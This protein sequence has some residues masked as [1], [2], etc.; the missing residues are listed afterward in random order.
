MD[1]IDTIMFYED[2]VYGNRLLIS[3]HADQSELSSNI[4]AARS[5]LFSYND[6]NIINNPHTFSFEHKNPE[7]TI[8]S[9]LGD[10]KGIMSEKGVAAGF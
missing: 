2:E 4:R 1:K 10:R 8:N 5:V 7:Y 3:D 9:V 6:I